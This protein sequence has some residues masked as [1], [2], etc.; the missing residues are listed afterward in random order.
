MNLIFLNQKKEMTERTGDVG[1][2]SAVVEDLDAGGSEE[3]RQHEDEQG[4]HDDD[5]QITSK[6]VSVSVV[7]RD[8]HDHGPANAPRQEDLAS[9]YHPHLKR[10]SIHPRT[11]TRKFM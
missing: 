1:E 10:P 6:A 11:K 2:M 7:R 4:H 9:R 3:G 5:A 8:L